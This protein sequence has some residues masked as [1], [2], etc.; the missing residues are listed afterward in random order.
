MSM[1]VFSIWLI[2]WYVLSA[3]RLLAITRAAT[4]ATYGAAIEVPSLSA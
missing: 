3:P 2:T 1:A 4:P